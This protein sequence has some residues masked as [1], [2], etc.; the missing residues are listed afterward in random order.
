[1]ISYAD[2]DIS[3][4]SRGL[5]GLDVTPLTNSH[6]SHSATQI[7]ETENESARRHYTSFYALD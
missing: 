2:T 5:S 6:R 4:S 7:L 1:M 3:V